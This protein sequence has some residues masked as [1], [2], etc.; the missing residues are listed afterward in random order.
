MDACTLCGKLTEDLTVVDD[1]DR[2]CPACLDANYTRCSRCG[3][4]YTDVID[5]YDVDGDDVCE[6]CFE[7]EED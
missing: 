4:Y 5:F 7:D 3:E 2:V 1:E 6:Y